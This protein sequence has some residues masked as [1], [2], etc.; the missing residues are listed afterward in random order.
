MTNFKI[1]NVLLSDAPQFLGSPKMLHNSDKPVRRDGSAW[2][3]EGPGT[4]DFTTFFNSLSVVKWKR[5]TVARA[6]RLHLELKGAACTVT[7]TRADS[8]SWSPERVDGRTVSLPASKTWQT[9]DIELSAADGDAI[10][11]FVIECEGD[12]SIRDSY[13]YVAVDEKDVR[14]VELALCTTTFKKE[15]YITRN[16][17][18]VRREI[19][20]SSDPI[21][22]HFSMHV[23]DNGRTLDAEALSGDGVEVHPNDNVGGAGGFARGMICAMEQ[24][25]KATHVL[26][27]DDDVLVSPESIIRTFNLLSL[28]NDEYA[29]A[30]VSGAMMNMDEPNLRWEEMGFIGFDGAFHPVKPVAHMDVLHDVADNEAFELPPHLPGYEDQ[31]QHYAAWWYCV[32]PMAQIERNGLPLPIFVR[33]DDVEYSRR[34]KP[35]FMTMNG[36]CIWHMA[37]HLRYNAAQERYQMTRNCFIDQFTSDFAPKANFERQM[38]H[39][40]R[41]ELNKFNYKNAALVLDGFEDFLK[42]PEW[43]MQ[44]VAQ[45]AFMD[46]NKNAEKFVP[47]SECREELEALGDDVDSLTTWEVYRDKAIS[48]REL[49]AFWRTSNG[50]VGPSLLMKTEKGK[51]AVIDGVGWAYPQGKIKGAETIVAVDMPG[52]AAAV[53]RCDPEKC[54]ELLNRFDRD[55]REYRSRKDELKRAYSEARAEMTSVSFWKTYL[56]I[57]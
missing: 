9:V 56:G 17:E 7:Q 22:S 31:E 37:F 46:A 1:M 40:F 52:R 19:L 14:P 20:G 5:Y 8:L 32:I 48:R 41:M 3:L 44:P 25:T 35:K 51:V 23:V 6:Y 45:K 33:G 18:L 42:G 10:E 2:V 55:M 24:P 49:M 36:I 30:F 11:G 21:A 53:R 50:Q 16:I 54:R 39:S 4:H 57:D 12:V 43:I 13:Y 15:D 47:F 26:L 34:C 38:R 28:V 29:E 27:M